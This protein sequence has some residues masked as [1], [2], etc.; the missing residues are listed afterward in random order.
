LL[1]KTAAKKIVKSPP[2]AS[3]SMSRAP[4]RLLR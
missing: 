1:V 3:I 2:N 4:S